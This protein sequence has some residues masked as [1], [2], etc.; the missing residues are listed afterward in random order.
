MGVK[1]LTVDAADRP[2]LVRALGRWDL[3]FILINSTIG[4]GIL[5][6]PGKVYA[7]LGVYSIGACLAGGVL[8]GLV[9]AC[10]AEAASRY[11]GTGASILYARAAFGPPTG[12]M[13]GWIA[14]A[15]RLFAYASICNLA[16][17]YAAGLW[18]LIAQ[19]LGRVV[20][21]T[22]LS[23]GLGGVIYA[24]VA[25]SARANAL[26]TL[27]KLALLIGFVLGGLI[28]LFPYHVAPLPPLPPAGRW[29]PAVV[30]L[31]FGLIGLDSAVVNGEE[32]RH[33]R[34]D[35][36][37]AIFL[38]LVVV[39]ALYSAILIVCA[40]VV[41]DLANSKRPLFDGA[42]AMFGGPAGAVVVIG[43]LISMSGTLFTILFTGPRLVF[44]LAE[45]G[46]LPAP[47][48]S[49][50]PRFRTP[51]T[52]IIAHT[53]LAWALA[54][55]SSFLGALT[56][57][58]LTR[59]M[60]YGLTAAS[61]LVLRRRNLSETPHPLLLPGGREIAIAACLLCAWLMLQS[62]RSAWLAALACLTLGGVVATAWRAK[63]PADAG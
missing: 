20:A 47:L 13:T 30:L 61:L 41:P 51:G 24:G 1:N 19:P 26:F 8:V 14:V 49:V 2:G 40:G 21:I 53:L 9:G 32:M 31:L 45:T 62:D 10:Y 56:A 38:G 59:L 63:P 28:Y 52:A 36:P 15:T 23:G 29:S 44:S 54:V 46:Q 4:A 37:F 16:V 39:V 60:L 25:L 34:R 3:A 43:A 48:A 57:S 33:P 35:I 11:P 6:L 12:F 55:T 58:T 17:G 5:G 42:V 18:P 22:L 27:A 7:L 50:H